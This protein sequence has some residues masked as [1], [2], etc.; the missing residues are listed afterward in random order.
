M[1]K[2]LFLALLVSILMVFTVGSALAG[3]PTDKGLPGAHNGLT[4]AEFGTAV[5]SVDTA[6]LVNH[7]GGRG[8]T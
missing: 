8:S 6:W 2:I 7:V 3:P 4:G 5:S 1:K